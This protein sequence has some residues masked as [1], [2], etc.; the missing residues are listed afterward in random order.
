METLNDKE[1]RSGIRDT[2]LIPAE[3]NTPIFRTRSSPPPQDELD[4][5]LAPEDVAGVVGYL[6]ALRHPV[7]HGA[8]SAA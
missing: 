5:M 2:H 1:G 4:L 8:V 3:V 7:R 6:T